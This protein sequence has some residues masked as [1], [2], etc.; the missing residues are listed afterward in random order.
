MIN[1][2]QCIILLES[3]P[4]KKNC[5]GKKNTMLDTGHSLRVMRDTPTVTNAQILLN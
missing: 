5:I 1:I 4:G 2:K 3:H